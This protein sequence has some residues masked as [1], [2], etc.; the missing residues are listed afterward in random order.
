M[1]VLH[2]TARL[3]SLA[4]QECYLTIDEVDARHLDQKPGFKIK[5][6]DESCD[7]TLTFD[8]CEKARLA[9][10]W[11]AAAV[12]KTDS[13]SLPT[14]CYR[15]QKEAYRFWHNESSYVWYFN[16]ATDGQSD[17]I[18]EPVCQ[19]KANRSCLCSYSR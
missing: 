11:K 17:S 4:E 10:D 16:E 9:L 18:S 5:G 3:A 19:G 13:T 1:F 8:Q 2:N 14:G 7:E 15:Q 6:K 12:E